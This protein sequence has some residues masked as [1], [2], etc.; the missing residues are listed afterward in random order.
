MCKL[1]GVVQVVQA[2]VALFVKHG[3]TAPEESID[4]IFIVSI[5]RAAK[6]EAKGLVMSGRCHEQT[7][8]LSRKLVPDSLPVSH[9]SCV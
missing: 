9:G 5:R 3:L 8:E 1:L 7:S 2:R 6:A 4:C